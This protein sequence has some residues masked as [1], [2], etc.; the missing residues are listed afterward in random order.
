[1]EAR[2]AAILALS[3]QGQQRLRVFWTAVALLSTMLLHEGHQRHHQESWRP[4]QGLRTETT[5]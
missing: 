5:L 4:Q 1:M 2:R 3:A